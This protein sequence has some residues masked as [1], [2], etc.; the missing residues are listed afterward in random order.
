MANKVKFGLRNVYYAKQSVNSE[1]GAITYATPVHIDGAVNLALSPV[2]D[3]AEL[4]AEDSLYFTQA[5][6]QG[7]SGDLEMALIS[8]TFLT[9]IMGME[10]DDND[11]LIENADQVP[12]PFALGFEI[13]GDATGKKVWFYNCT[14]ARPGQEA[15]TKTNSIEPTTD[16]LSIVVSPRLTDKQVKVVLTLSDTNISAYNSF[17]TDVYEEVNASA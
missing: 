17:F 14:C 4:F 16:K 3:T 10:T 12:S 11:A 7:Y 6:N 13:Q 1:T 5:N 2:G 8:D 15:S 9:D